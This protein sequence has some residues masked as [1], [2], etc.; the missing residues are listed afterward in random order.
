MFSYNLTAHYP[1]QS[2]VGKPMVAAHFTEITWKPI[3]AYN[4]QEMP[5]FC[6]I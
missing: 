2:L 4:A 6:H 5:Y 3:T 1:S